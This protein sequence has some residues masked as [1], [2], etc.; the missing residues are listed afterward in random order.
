[1]VD[2]SKLPNIKHYL[3][4]NRVPEPRVVT[5]SPASLRLLKSI[6]GLQTCN[7]KYITAFNDMLVYEQ[8]GNAYMRFNNKMHRNSLFVQAQNL[9]LSRLAS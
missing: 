8:A 5:L 3:E 2:P 6:G 7:H 4:E 9:L 1:M